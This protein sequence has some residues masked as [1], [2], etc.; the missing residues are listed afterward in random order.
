MTKSY[1]NVDYL[2][3]LNENRLEQYSAHY[4]KVQGRFTNI[5]I[6]YSGVGIFITPLIKRC[7]DGNFEEWLFLGIFLIFLIF[8]IISI[9]NTIHLLKPIEIAHLNSPKIY[10]EDLIKDYEQSP[11][12]FEEKIDE[13]GKKEVFVNQEKVD[14]YLKAS[15]IGELEE[16]IEK[17]V[18]AVIKKSLRY[19][20]SLQYGLIS[21]VPF[22]ICV[23]IHLNGEVE[24]I[25][26]IEITN[27]D[28]L[29]QKTQSIMSKSNPSNSHGGNGSKPT[30]KIPGVDRSQVKPVSPRM[31]KNSKDVTSTKRDK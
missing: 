8:F 4:D 3:E 28:E 15:Y 26:K 7:F 14:L 30:A 6:L 25:S 22:L 19:N 16:A 10:Y 1:Y 29:N 2:I 17:N 24:T 21:I 31:I 27:I 9:I 18:D 23:L 13:N 12:F 5:I 11:S 20:K